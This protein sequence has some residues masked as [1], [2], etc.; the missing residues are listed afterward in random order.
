MPLRMVIEPIVEGAVYS[1]VGIFSEF[2]GE[3]FGESVA[4]RLPLVKRSYSD[5]YCKSFFCKQC[6][7]MAK[8]KRSKRGWYLYHCHDCGSS[9]GVLR[10]K[11]WVRRERRK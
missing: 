4:T 8:G 3:L 10:S 1:A 11:P 6:P 7:G 5:A 9:W 2:V